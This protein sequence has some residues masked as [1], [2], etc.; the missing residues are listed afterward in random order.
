MIKL[1]DILNEGK[2]VITSTDNKSELPSNFIDFTVVG[3]RQTYD[4]KPVISFIP[5]TSKDLDKKDQL[6]N[7]SKSDVSKQLAKFAEKKTKLKF[8]S[9]DGYEGAG[10]AITL[11]VESIIKKIK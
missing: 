11:D 1:T 5:R 2:I 4:G 10:Y 3:G 6:G 8:N 7:T 9:F